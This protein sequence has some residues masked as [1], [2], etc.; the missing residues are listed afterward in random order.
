MTS[1][2]V[3]NGEVVSPAKLSAFRRHSDFV[4]FLFAWLM[5]QMGFASTHRAS[6]GRFALVAESL[7]LLPST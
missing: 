7:I 6:L 1:M 5:A 4:I 2:H 3:S